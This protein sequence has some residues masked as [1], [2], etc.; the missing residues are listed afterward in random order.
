MRISQKEK[1]NSKPPIIYLER[2]PQPLESHTTSWEGEIRV[3]DVLV[4][5]FDSKL[6]KISDY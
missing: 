6:S 2:K 1:P 4:G 5:I 3:I